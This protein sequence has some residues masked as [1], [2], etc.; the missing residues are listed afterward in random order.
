[1][2]KSFTASASVDPINS[3]STDSFSVP[4]C[5]SAANRRAASKSLPSSL[6][7]PTIIRLGYRLSYKALDSLKNSGLNRILDV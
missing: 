4:S 2:A 6:S 3:V 5:K 1:M 7:T